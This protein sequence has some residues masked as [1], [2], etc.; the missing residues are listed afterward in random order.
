MQVAPPLLSSGKHFERYFDQR[1][2]NGRLEWRGSGGGDDGGKVTPGLP[3]PS[4]PLLGVGAGRPAFLVP[5]LAI[6][7]P[8]L[9]GIVIWITTGDLQK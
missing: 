1:R 2:S 7:T 9:S 5:L 4:F 6:F 8:G 3:R